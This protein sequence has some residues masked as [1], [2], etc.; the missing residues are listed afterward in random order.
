MAAHFGFALPAT[1][2]LDLLSQSG[3]LPSFA[4]YTLPG[5][6]RVPIHILLALS[7]RFIVVDTSL[8]ADLS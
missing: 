7:Q 4:G 1:C 3:L 6:M 8:C 5:M 2:N